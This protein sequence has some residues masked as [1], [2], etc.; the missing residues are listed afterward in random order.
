[1]PIA[2]ESK[3]TRHE[4]KDSQKHT[5]CLICFSSVTYAYYLQLSLVILPG[6]VVAGK[7][8]HKKNTCYEPPIFL[9]NMQHKTE[10]CLVKLLTEHIS[11][12]KNI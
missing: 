7:W 3:Q 4:I 6:L 12:Q 9:R 11:E 5:V 1:M 10:S 2:N 8:S